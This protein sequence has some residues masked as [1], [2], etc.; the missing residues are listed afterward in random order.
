VKGRYRSAARSAVQ[1][2]GRG[3]RCGPEAVSGDMGF[4]EQWHEM[5]VCHHF[6][7]PKKDDKN[8]ENF[9]L[10]KNWMRN[11]LFSLFFKTWQSEFVFL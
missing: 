2:G 8:F 1:V 9:Y 11:V 4:K 7:L 3:R 10:I 5:F 6:I